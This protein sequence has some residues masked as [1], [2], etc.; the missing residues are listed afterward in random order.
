M[1][2]AR[3]APDDVPDLLVL[4]DMQFDCAHRGAGGARAWETAHERLAR[5]FAEA[6]VAACGRPWPA[7]TV[8]F[9]NLRGDTRGHAA[10]ADARG[11]RLLSGYS[12]ALLKLVLSGSAEL[13]ARDADAAARGG[14]DA[15]AAARAQPTPWETLRACLDDARYDAVRA[16]LAAV[17]RAPDADAPLRGYAWAPPEAAAEEAEAKVAAVGLGDMDDD[18][19]DAVLV[20]KP[21]SPRA[22]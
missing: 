17:A 22:A 16:R 8:T 21:S 14:G 12:P 7:P 11:V 20:E 1:R 2:P 10:R 18:D 6:G 19:D 13:D 3:C 9:W 15:A 5:R 4:S